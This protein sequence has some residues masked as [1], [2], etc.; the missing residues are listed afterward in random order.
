MR[1]VAVA[2]HNSI[3]RDRITILVGEDDG[4]STGIVSSFSLPPISFPLAGSF[5]FLSLFTCPGGNV[6]N[7]QSFLFLFFVAIINFN[8]R[9]SMWGTNSRQVFKQALLFSRVKILVSVLLFQATMLRILMNP[10]V[11]PDYSD[12]SHNSLLRVHRHHL[13]HSERIAGSCV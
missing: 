7:T 2:T 4:T 10:K 5:R 1:R 3:R 12:T 13:Y 9:G 11:H 8:C 6:L